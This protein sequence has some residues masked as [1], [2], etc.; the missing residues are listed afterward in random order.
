MLCS[1][2]RR[3]VAGTAREVFHGQATLRALA[4]AQARSQVFPSPP[5]RGRRRILARRSPRRAAASPTRPPPSVPPTPATRMATASSVSRCP[6]PAWR[7]ARAAGRSAQTPAPRKHACTKPSA[8][9]RISFSAAASTPTSAGISAPRS[10]AGGRAR[11]CSIRPGADARRDR[12]LRGVPTRPGFDRDEYPPAVGRGRGT[13]PRRGGPTRA[14]G[15]RTCASRELREPLARIVARGQAA[16]LLQ[17]HALPL[18]LLLR[19]RRWGLAPQSVPFARQRIHQPRP[20]RIR[21]GP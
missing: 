6:A 14:A 20:C 10:R 11:S 2:I 15:R 19:A 17:R 7:P 9:Q 4:G 12:L 13:R 21:P 1:R 16:A 3:S 8:V 5:S 18:R